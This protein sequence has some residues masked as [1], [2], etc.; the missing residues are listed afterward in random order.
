VAGT[1]NQVQALQRVADLWRELLQEMLRTNPAVRI[2]TVNVRKRVRGIVDQL[3][4]CDMAGILDASTVLSP[5]TGITP[6]W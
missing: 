1:E 5:G 2:T 4:A 6:L 3:E